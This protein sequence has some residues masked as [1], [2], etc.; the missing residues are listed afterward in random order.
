VSCA[1][2]KPAAA[3]I[4]AAVALLA[5]PGTPAQAGSTSITDASGLDFDAA[6]VAST[7]LAA[8]GPNS[9]ASSGGSGCTG[10]SLYDGS[11][12]TVDINGGVTL[13]TD[14]GG[15]L[16]VSWPFGGS[17]P[18]GGSTDLSAADLPSSNFV[19]FNYYVMFQNKSVETNVP[20]NPKG[21]CT[22]VGLGN[23]VFDRY[24]SWRDGY[25]FF[26]SF[27][28]NYNGSTWI[29]S[30]QVGEY[31]PGPEGGF[32]FY[33]LAVKDGSGW[34]SNNVYHPKGTGP[35]DWDVGFTGSAITVAVPG[36]YKEPDQLNCGE[37]FMR[38][39]FVSPGDNIA[40]VKALT[41]ANE[42]YTLSVPVTTTISCSAISDLM[43]RNG[44]TTV[45]GYAFIVDTTDG[46]STTGLANTNITGIAYSPG[47]IGDAAAGTL[48][49][50]VDEVDTAAET[51]TTGMANMPDTLGDGPTCPTPTFGGLLPTNPLFT[52]DAACQI[53]DDS[54][55][56]GSIL[57]ELWDTA[58][59]FTA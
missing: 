10:I 56:R 55:A 21:G 49:N 29:R 36:V 34:H 8:P 58:H 32:S 16:L 43:C 3:I 41:T 7:S 39:A 28:A 2:W 6:C 26:V 18:D 50:A 27:A 30:I 9:H 48:V 59:G 57:P 46:N 17:V 1:R 19:G 12:R 20:T 40:N 53:D 38:H 25:H 44:L 23:Q 45:G 24:G 14:A 42:V 11:A 31:E 22:R 4:A 51:R 15:R 33:E 5:L 52:P 47:A 37:G 35:S 13:G 54:I